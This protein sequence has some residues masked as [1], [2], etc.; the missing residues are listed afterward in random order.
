MARKVE[1]LNYPE[2]EVSGVQYYSVFEVHTEGV[3]YR[4][5]AIDLTLE[6]AKAYIAEHGELND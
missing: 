3:K 2:P 6:E 4:R 5:V 1:Y